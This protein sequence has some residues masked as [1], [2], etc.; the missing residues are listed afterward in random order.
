[1]YPPP[2]SSVTYTVEPSSVKV[3]CVIRHIRANKK[4]RQ[5]IKWRKLYENKKKKNLERKWKYT[6]WANIL[7]VRPDPLTLSLVL[8]TAEKILAP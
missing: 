5:P 8:V 7:K 2:P 3:C 4:R 6:E 1:M